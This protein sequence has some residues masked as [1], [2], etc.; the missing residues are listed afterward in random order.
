MSSSVNRSSDS[1]QSSGDQPAETPSVQAPHSETPTGDSP[2]VA[3]NSAATADSTETTPTDV[4]RQQPIPPPSEPMQYRAIGLIRGQYMPSAEQLTRGTLLAADG[5]L[6]DAV[7]LGRVMSLVKNHLSLD[8]SHLWVVYPRSRQEDGNLHVQIVGV[9]EPEKLNQPKSS[10]PSESGE[11]ASKPEVDTS[12]EVS[13]PE[14][15]PVVNDGYFSIRGEVIYQSKEEEQVIIKIRQSP[16]RQSEK[17]KF[18]KLKLKGSLGDRVVGHFWDLHVQLQANTLTIQEANDIGLMP[19]KKR[20]GRKPFPGR[21]SDG[22]KNVSNQRPVRKGERPA[23]ATPP[24]RREA[25]P[26]PIKRS[27]QRGGGGTSGNSS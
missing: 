10:E 27:E 1:P 24:K 21:R 9:W 5:T 16:R 12:L 13:E 26:K 2:E 22:R 7:L 11:E 3:T 25:V 17:I 15:S 19:V 8:Q 23:P 20:T 4:Q 18:F 14:A 6:I